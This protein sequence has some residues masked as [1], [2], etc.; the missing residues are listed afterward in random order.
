MTSKG[1]ASGEG[2]LTFTE[3]ARRE[4]ITARAIEVI[5][6]R[7]YAK[8]SLARIADAA[9]ISNAAVLYHF[10]SK[11]AVLESAYS[12]V[13]DGLVE[14]V[15]TAMAGT[16]SAAKSIEAYIRALVDYV[17][18]H[19]SYTRIIVEALTTGDLG[20]SNRPPDA[21][22][23][24]KPRWAPLAEAMQQAQDEGDFRP[25]EVRTYAIAV[26]GAIDAIFVESLTDPDYDLDRAVDEL[27]GLLHHA[28]RPSPRDAS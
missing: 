24:D 5:A 7:G 10:G 21:D 12:T 19:P 26:G 25:F 3:S 17:A 9:G 15:S 22:T 13:I 20:T 28:M 27:V 23:H 8:T 18:R 4:Q 16:S 14:S 2:G 1:G 11:A 6:E